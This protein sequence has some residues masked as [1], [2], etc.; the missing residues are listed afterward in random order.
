MIYAY[1]LTAVIIG[2][3]MPVQAGLNSGL[4]RELKHP[5]AG[6]FISLTTGAILVLIIVL[7]KGGGPASLKR[8]SQVSPH[9]FLGGVLGAIFVG[10]SLYLIPRMGATA[11][12]GAF[13]TGQLIGSVLIDHYG[14]LGITPTPLNMTRVIGVMLLFTGLLFVLKKTP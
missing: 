12:I 2:I 6:A 13:I 14:L 4:T 1:I 3:F 11:M 7:I 5:F 9:L 10:S 8:L